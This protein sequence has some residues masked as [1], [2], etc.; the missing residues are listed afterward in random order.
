VDGP[1]SPKAK[2]ADE[3]IGRFVAEL[4]AGLSEWKKYGKNTRP[5]FV[6]ELF[7]YATTRFPV[8]RYD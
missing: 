1:N 5:P 7:N 6:C 2:S 4:T 8:T 3:M